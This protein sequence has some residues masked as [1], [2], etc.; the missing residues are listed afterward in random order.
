M[1]S[2]HRIPE[3]SGLQL[4]AEPSERWWVVFGSVVVGGA[5]VGVAVG[6]G[7]GEDTVGVAGDVPAVVGFGD[8]AE[9]GQGLQVGGGRAPAAAS[10]AVR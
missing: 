4:T 7:P 2:P 1:A 8:V 5:G 9:F 10:V 6:A 3:T